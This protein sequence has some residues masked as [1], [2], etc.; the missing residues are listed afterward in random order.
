V[1]DGGGIDRVELR[2]PERECIRYDKEG[3]NL[4]PVMEQIKAEVD[5]R[6]V[7]IKC[8]D[9]LPGE[10]VADHLPDIVTGAATVIKEPA[11]SF[12]RTGIEEMV[13]DS[14]FPENHQDVRVEDSPF[15]VLLQKYLVISRGIDDTP[16]FD[17]FHGGREFLREC[18]SR[19]EP[20][21]LRY[22]HRRVRVCQ[23]GIHG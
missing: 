19:W 2:W 23:Q 6:P 17:P 4:L 10:S 16:G 13:V 9:L 3:A 12:E 18:L 15:G 22:R 14:R 20:V 21:G 5:A 1:E 7:D 8:G 11:G